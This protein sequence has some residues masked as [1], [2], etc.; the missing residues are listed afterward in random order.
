[1][2]ESKTELIAL[3]K[4]VGSDKSDKDFPVRQAIRLFNEG[5]Y[6]EAK[7]WFEKASA[8]VSSRAFSANVRLCNARIKTLNSQYGEIRK[9]FY[10]KGAIAEVVAFLERLDRAG[11]LKRDKNRSE[12][13]SFV[14]GLHHLRDGWSHIPP[15]QPNPGHFPIAKSV[16]YCLHQSVPN[17]TNGYSTRSHGVAKG[18]LNAGFRVHC[19]TRP[20]F[21]WDTVSSGVGKGCHEQ[22]IDNIS[23]YAEAGWPLNKTPL[24]HYLAQAA[25]LFFRRA[26]LTGSELIV[27]AS[28]HITGLPALMAARRLGVPFVYEVRG[29]WEVTQASV[30]PDWNHSDRFRLMRTLEQQ[31]CKEADQ[32]IT[33]TDELSRELQAWGVRADRISIV[34]NA[35]D[36]NAFPVAEPD[37]EIIRE[38]GLRHGT[39]V[40]GYAGS[41]VAYEGLELLIEALALMKQRGQDFVF[42]LVGDGKAFESVKNRATALSISEQCRFV[43]RVAFDQVQRYI[44]CMEIMPVPRLSSSV[45]EMVSALK[46]LEAMAMGKAVVLSDVSPHRPMAGENAER[47][48][49]FEKDS[50]ASLSAALQHLI[51][52]PSDRQR[53]G[54][55]AR[56][57]I[58]HERTW[59]QVTNRYADALKRVTQQHRA[60]DSTLEAKGLEQITIGLIADQFTTDTLVSALRVVPLSPENWQAELDAQPLDAVLIESAWK[61]NQGQWY[62]KVGFYSEEEFA[63]LQALLTA[64]RERCIPSLFWNK[65]DPVHFD[66]FRRAASLCDLV[67]TTD[68][69]RIIPYLVTHNGKTKT[70]SSCPFYASPK[71]HNLLPSTRQWQATAAYGGTYYGKRYPERSE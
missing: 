41:I 4:Q 34:P 33:I 65:E 28:N 3:P 1:M 35:V 5:R 46:P 67:F 50:A 71:L 56:A 2:S 44:S 22:I 47:A 58:E 27:A 45:T 26:Q 54:L 32:I 23:Y 21:P 16:L 69:R 63:P 55:A 42:V 31:V 36:I 24:D 61:G 43:G 64:C 57:W 25:D 66:R 37:P 11:E 30:Q 62:R 15:R 6:R 49:L 10:G 39:P 7:D 9:D 20:G 40:I 17:A 59:N 51:D 14:Y 38:L 68:S 13:S 60:A 70:A 29:L 48:L 12:F 8:A 19:V 53:L 18:L 52:H